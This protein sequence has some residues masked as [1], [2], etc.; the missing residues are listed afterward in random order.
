MVLQIFTCLVQLEIWYEDSE[1]LLHRLISLLHAL[2][3]TVTDKPLDLLQTVTLKC[4]FSFKLRNLSQDCDLTQRDI[5]PL[6]CPDIICAIL[7]S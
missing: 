3:L 6:I 5:L 7:S 4:L 1:S 2:H